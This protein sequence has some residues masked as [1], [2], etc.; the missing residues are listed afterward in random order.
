[1][2]VELGPGLNSELWG[3]LVVKSK[4]WGSRVS[5]F[6]LWLYHLLATNHLKQVM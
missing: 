1:M 2:R 5:G 6:K 4:D 3:G